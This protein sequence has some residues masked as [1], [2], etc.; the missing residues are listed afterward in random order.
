MKKKILS[1]LFLFAIFVSSALAQRAVTG[2]VSDDS[3]EPLPG[4][5]VVIPG[6]SQGSVSDQNGNFSVNIYLE[7][8]PNLVEVIASDQYGNENSVTIVVTYVP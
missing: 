7:E 4:V 2:V 5:T 3:G 6:T 8:G 1:L